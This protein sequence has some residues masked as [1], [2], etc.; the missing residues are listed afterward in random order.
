MH[1]E[2]TNRRIGLNYYD[3]TLL[4]ERPEEDLKI[5][6]PVKTSRPYSS[7]IHGQ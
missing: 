6:H 4:A 7:K 3:T 1:F 2:Q 5:I